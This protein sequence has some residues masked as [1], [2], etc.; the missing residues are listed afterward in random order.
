[1][2][3]SSAAR[4]LELLDD[5]SELPQTTPQLLGEVIALSGSD[6]FLLELGQLLGAQVIVRPTE[7]LGSLADLVI[8]TRAQ[9]LAVECSDA[10]AFERELRA[11][12]VGPGRLPTVAFVAAEAL[13]EATPPLRRAGVRMVLPLPLA[14]DETRAVLLREL[15]AARN[16]VAARAAAGE[17]LSFDAP[18]IAAASSEASSGPAV[19][20]PL[21]LAAIAML[22]LAAAGAAW[23]FL[24]GS[25]SGIHASADVAPQPA[26]AGE[27]APEAAPIVGGPVEELLEKARTAMR[28]RRYTDP[29]DD[30]ALLYFRSAVAQEPDNA[31]ALDGIQRLVALLT[32]R[33][34]Q[35]LDERRTEVAAQ[36]AGDLRSIRSRDPQVTALELRL[37]GLQMTT[38]LESGDTERIAGA[39]RQAAQSGVVPQPQL[40]QWRAELG[41]RQDADRV[42]RLVA[43]G[44][45]RL[46]AG[47]LLEPPNANARHF[48][49]QAL[50]L[51]PDDAAAQ[52]LARDVAAAML[53]HARDAGL[54]TP[55]GERWLAEARAL[56]ATPAQIAALQA[57]E[58]ASR[59]PAPGDAERA[60][61][62]NRAALEAAAQ[63]R[64]A[65]QAAQARRAEQLAQEQTLSASGR[66]VIAHEK[67]RR[68][69]AVAP[70]Y[71]PEAA[72]RGTAG[73]VTVGFVVNERG[74]P[75]DVQVLAS[76]PQGVFD[77]VAVG[78][79]RRWRYAPWLV[80]GQAVAIETS[81]NIRFSPADQVR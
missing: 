44:G 24:S 33:L 38:A 45:E 79:V 80:D 23:Y 77:R 56:G 10:G 41:R 48:A 70:G 22:V 3:A 34:E 61:E 63:E 76:E 39:L 60:A 31:E 6:E 19:S 26:A 62:A 5:G 51:A 37:Y 4:R 35:A 52:R 81:L 40:N 18:Q 58:S 12:A 71:P 7:S 27:T 69:R 57:R 8:P 46:R 1:M 16:E 74:E 30:S 15:E 13:R 20:T 9:I 72:R 47:Q 42:A 32:A 55:E 17:R 25:G 68:T 59:A 28:D 36:A 66:P 54:R 21:L 67:L 75:Q 78:A 65:Q 53:Q 73:R 64:A 49:T 50:Q 29:R 11:A 2:D 14:S 43:Q